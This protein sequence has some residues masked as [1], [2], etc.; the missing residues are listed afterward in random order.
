[1]IIQDIQG[2]ANWKQSSWFGFQFV[3]VS[4]FTSLWWKYLVWI[5]QAKNN[6]LPHWFNPSWKWRDGRIHDG[7][8]FRLR[9]ELVDSFS[10]R[11]Q[12]LKCLQSTQLWHLTKKILK[13][14]VLRDSTYGST[15]LIWKA[16]S[17]ANS[18]SEWETG[19]AVRCSTQ[20]KKW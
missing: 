15:I 4:I 16:H 11:S 7:S 20:C 10:S 18:Q 2:E 8:T 13:A 9:F 5:T 14:W 3:F 6:Y 1:M 17:K 12:L 19:E